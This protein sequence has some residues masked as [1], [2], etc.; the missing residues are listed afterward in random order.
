M[1]T[2]TH[3][4]CARACRLGACHA[5]LVLLALGLGGCAAS[6]MRD[7]TL[8]PP[9][10]DTRHQSANQDS[11]VRYL[12]LHYTE[13]DF[14]SALETLTRGSVSSHYLVSADPPRSYRLVPEERRAWHAGK[15]YWRG[16][17]ALNA[18]S[19]GIEIVNPG[20]VDDALR[21][22]AP[23][24]EAQIDEVIRLVRDI[25]QRHGIAPHRILG[26][27]DIAPQRKIDPGPRF[28]WHR[29][30]EAGLIPWPDEAQVAVREADYRA[31]VPA[32]AWFQTKLARLGYEVPRSGV[33][34]EATRRALAI[35]QAKYLPSRYDGEADARTA[36]LLE[37]LNRPGGS[38][39]RLKDGSLALFDFPAD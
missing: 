39:L 16:E 30:F 34:D 3:R 27:G 32:P 22:F 18:S 33:L 9:H 37:V 35:F 20:P 11:R 5:L 25:V 10:I 19:I 17:T 26:H 13:L 38:V 28:P 2:P 6:G 14:P 1:K 8:A 23:Y 4:V 36:A 24:P 7:T 15:S 12:V 29:L 31:A 21:D